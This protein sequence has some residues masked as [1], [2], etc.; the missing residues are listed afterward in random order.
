MSDQYLNRWYP[1]GEMNICYNSVDRHV[2]EGRGDH[3]GLVYDS[4]YTGEQKSY[5]YKEIQE[6]VGITASQIKREYE[7]HP[8]N[9]R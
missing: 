1:D 8:N 4:A 9:L 7:E 3:V 6:N 5:T 2:D